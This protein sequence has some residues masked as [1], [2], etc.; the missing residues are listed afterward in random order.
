MLRPFILAAV[1]AAVPAAAAT[2][3]EP[4][5]LAES[6]PDFTEP[7]VVASSNGVLDTTLRVAYARNQIGR[8]P[9]CLRSYNGGLTGPTLRAATSSPSPNCRSPATRPR[10]SSS[11]PGS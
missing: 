4:L 5:V 1:L 2:A 7:R 6:H 8:D 9:V 3:G 10:T 11:S